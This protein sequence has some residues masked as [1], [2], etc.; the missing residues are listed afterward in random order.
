MAKDK[1]MIGSLVS[2]LDHPVY[3]SYFGEGLV[4][5]PR[6]VMKKIK[7]VGLGAIPR[8]VIFVPNK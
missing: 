1:K 8:G 3:L 6:G 4:V 5:P 2:R 7:K